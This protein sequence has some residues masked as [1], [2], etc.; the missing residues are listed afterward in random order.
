MQQEQ[1]WQQ[2]QWQ[3]KLESGRQLAMQKIIYTIGIQQLDK[4]LIT[5]HAN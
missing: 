5:N 1:Q 4:L 2:V 3:R